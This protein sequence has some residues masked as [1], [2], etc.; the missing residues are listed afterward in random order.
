MWSR[1]AGCKW[2]VAGLE[3]RNLNGRLKTKVSDHHIEMVTGHRLGVASGG[4]RVASR[5]IEMVAS[6]PR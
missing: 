3:L 2:R 5:E 4:S 1:V 6:R